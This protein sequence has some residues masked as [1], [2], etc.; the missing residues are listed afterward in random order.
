MTCRKVHGATFHAFTIFPEDAV[1]VTGR[2]GVFRTSAHGHRHF[3]ARCG[4]H[5]FMR[6]DGTGEIEVHIGSF[7][8][9]GQFRPTYESWVG[10]REP[11]QPA[12]AARQYGG[13]REGTGRTE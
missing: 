6:E 4:S 9:P 1:T 11:W 13:N 2:P 5:V 10:R 7:D 3:C 12:V 8:A